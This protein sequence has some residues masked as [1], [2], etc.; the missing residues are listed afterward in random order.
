MAQLVSKPPYREVGARLRRLR[1]QLQLPQTHAANLLGI[2]R[3]AL[4]QLERGQALPALETLCK[5]RQVYRTTY[6]YLLDGRHEVAGTTPVPAVAVTVSENH[7]PNIVLVP[8]RAQA[9]YAAG[10]LQPDYLAEFP[11]FHLPG[12][13]YRNA[14]YRAF[15]VAG[16]SMAPTL[17]NGDIVVCTLVS[18]WE[19]LWPDELYVFV[20][21]DD[22][23][24]KRLQTLA[25][26]RGQLLLKSDN[27]QYSPI[28][29]P[30]E[31]LAEVWRV[32]ARITQDL[33][34]PR[35]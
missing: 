30:T 6:A 16:S 27:P 35:T 28:A 13:Q 17:S 32:T 15:E 26:D 14:S 5:A 9:G 7:T 29:F 24:V 31:D 11:A 19:H 22:V 33:A 3:Q 2:S 20:L 18:N 1:E 12:G 25:E 8:V 34:P 23:L 21:A 4:S 10:R